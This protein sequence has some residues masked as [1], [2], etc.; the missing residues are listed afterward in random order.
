MP[1]K[2]LEDFKEDFPLLI[3]AGFVAVKQLDE[4]SA[5][6]LFHA[7]KLLNPESTAPDIGIGYIALN[8]L[9]VKEATGIFEKIVKIEPD[10]QLAKTF[11]G[12]SYL[13]T[14]AKRKKGEEIINQ[15]IKETSD[16]TIVNLG[17]IALEWAE[18]DL[19]KLKSPFIK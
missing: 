15:A 6:H 9:E 11:L 12:I 19:K 7:A 8:K 10:N 4:T 2:T 5:R 16:E 13:L 17:N 1:K 18:K 14:K 3:E